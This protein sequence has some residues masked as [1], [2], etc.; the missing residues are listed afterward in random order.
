MGITGT[1]GRAAE[2]LAASYL[3]LAG[4]QVLERNLRLGGV[5]IDVLAAE[6]EFQVLVEVKF[7]SRSDYGGALEAVDR[8][9]CRRLLRAASVLAARGHPAVRIDLV[10]VD[11]AP[12]GATL[13]HVRGAVSS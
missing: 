3:E 7:R 2:S 13:R 1:R 9:Q 6:R 8:T 10:A 5:E 11:L 12:D 4:L